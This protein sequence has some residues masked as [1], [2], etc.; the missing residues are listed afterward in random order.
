MATKTIP[1]NELMRFVDHTFKIKKG[2]YLFQEGMQAKGLYLILSGKV[3]VSKITEDGRELT[4]RLCGQNDIVGEAIIFSHFPTFL[5]TAKVIKDGE[6]AFISKEKMEE[7]LFKNG[8]FAM[9]F[10][11]WMSD[12]YR[13]T[14]TKF[15]DLLLHGKKG[16][17]FSTLIRMTNSYGVKKADGILID[18]PFTNQELGNFS[19]TSRES[20]NRMLSDLKKRGIISMSEGKIIIHD[21]Q[22][23]RDEIGCEGCPIM[24]CRLE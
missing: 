24:Y 20:V 10:M 3:Q 4:F 2:T 5:L 18:F 15:R 6:A 16:A 7:E 12:Q 22:Y 9:E 13:N 1:I 8:A 19:G 14:Q 11:K 21:L 17:V 23:L